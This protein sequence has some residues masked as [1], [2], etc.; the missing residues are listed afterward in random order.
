LDSPIVVLVCLFGACDDSG[1]FLL[2]FFISSF[3]FFLA[4]PLS[5]RAR[6]VFGISAILGC[7]WIALVGRLAVFDV[8]RLAFGL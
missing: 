6:V 8:A 1:S 5:L 3:L 2:F 4:F 7:Y